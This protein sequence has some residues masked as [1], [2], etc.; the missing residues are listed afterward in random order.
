[1]R[2]FSGLISLLAILGASL[3]LTACG[4]D[5]M[6]A[7]SELATEDATVVYLLFLIC[8]GVHFDWY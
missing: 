3:A 4:S 7:A 1:M 6:P 2:T 5:D 8:L